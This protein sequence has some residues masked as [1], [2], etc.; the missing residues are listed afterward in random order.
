MP[1]KASPFVNL[2]PASFVAFVAGS[3]AAVLVLV[4]VLDPELAIHFEVTP[5][6]TV[7]FYIT[8]FAS[9]LGVARGM[10]PEENR[11]FDPELLMTEVIQYTHY[12]PDEWK[13][14][15]HSKQVSLSGF[16][17]CVTFD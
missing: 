3:F 5:H 2:C 14:Q 1:S 8:V 11:V 6:R 15:L 16:T 17:S 12:M 4:S 9:I 7:L 10:I 13:D